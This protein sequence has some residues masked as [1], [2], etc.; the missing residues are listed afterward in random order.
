MLVFRIPILHQGLAGNL[1]YSPPLDAWLDGAVSS[2]KRTPSS[3]EGF[4]YRFRSRL[5]LVLANIPDTL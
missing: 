4:L 2:Q 3:I 1:I 5:L